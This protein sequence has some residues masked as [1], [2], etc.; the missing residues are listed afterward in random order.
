MLRIAW[1][2]SDPFR[3]RGDRRFLFSLH[4]DCRGWARNDRRVA[5]VRSA[6][7]LDFEAL[8]FLDEASQVRYAVVYRSGQPI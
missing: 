5:D 3:E 6:A 7:R 4:M 2:P 8:S 1:M